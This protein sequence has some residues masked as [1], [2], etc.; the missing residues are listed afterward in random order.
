MPDFCKF[1]SVWVSTWN[2]EDW[3]FTLFLIPCKYVAL[4]VLRASRK[5]KRKLFM[6]DLIME[7]DGPYHKVFT[8]SLLL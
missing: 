1:E 8:I 2:F 6:V 5:Y 7:I 3:L 4:L